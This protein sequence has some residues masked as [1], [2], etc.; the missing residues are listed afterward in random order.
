MPRL[1][2]RAKGLALLVTREMGKPIGESEAEV[3]KC[4]VGLEYCADHAQDFLA[5]ERFD[6][7]ADQSWVSYEPV[8]IV[9]ASCPGTSRYGRSFGSLRPR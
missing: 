3:E 4:A 6:T 9:L 5:D 1:R 8:G 2:S 7:D